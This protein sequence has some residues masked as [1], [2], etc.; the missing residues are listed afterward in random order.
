QPFLDHLRDSG[1]DVADASVAN[2]SITHLSLAALLNMS[3]MHADGAN[4]GRN[5][6]QFLAGEIAGANELVNVLKENGYTYVHAETTDWHNRCGEHVDVC[7]PGSSPSITT[8][9]VLKGTLIGGLIFRDTVD[10]ATD[11]NVA[12]IDQLV[13]WR[14]TTASW[15][16]APTFSFF[17]LPLPHPPL[18]LDD[19]CRV[20]AEPELSGRI[21]NDGNMSASQLE[22]RRQAWVEQIQ[23]ANRTIKT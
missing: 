4:I 5:D 6:L 18:F 16:E 20:R 8:Y 13:K 22:K 14:Q 19:Q 7:L 17:H 10:P 12:R 9:S 1:F 3:Y 23:C 2:Y 21:M 11:L 15:T